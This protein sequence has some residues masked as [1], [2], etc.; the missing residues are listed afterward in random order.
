M[1][2]QD[3]APAIQGLLND[4]AVQMFGMSV[5]EAI[6]TGVCVDCKQSVDTSAAEWNISGLCDDCFEKSM[7]E[8]E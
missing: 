8:D 2:F 4:M 3:K 1:A 5:S 6:H 7:G